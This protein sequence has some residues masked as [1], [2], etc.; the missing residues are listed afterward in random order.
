ME[1]GTEVVSGV[2]VVVVVVGVSKLMS[3]AGGGMAR[4]VLFFKPQRSLQNSPSER[5]DLSAFSLRRTLA[6]QCAVL[7]TPSMASSY[8]AP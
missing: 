7:V 1:E 6:F 4:P 5:I 2:G 8:V 3:K